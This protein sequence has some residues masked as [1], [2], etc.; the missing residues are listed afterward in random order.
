MASWLKIRRLTG[1]PLRE[2]HSD[3][4]SYVGRT[5]HLIVLDVAHGSFVATCNNVIGIYLAVSK[6]PDTWV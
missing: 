1:S 6:K 2:R 3:L 4:L 5:R